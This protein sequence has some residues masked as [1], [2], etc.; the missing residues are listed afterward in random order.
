MFEECEIQYECAKVTED[1]V[2]VKVAQ[3]WP[4][5]YLCIIFDACQCRRN[6]LLL[7]IRNYY[8]DAVNGKEFKGKY[9]ELISAYFPPELLRVC[10]IDSNR[11]SLVCGYYL[12]CLSLLQDYGQFSHF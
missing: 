11:I 8:V 6:N 12:Q 10:C 2:K 7:K 1:I 3:E 9:R 5:S 4:F